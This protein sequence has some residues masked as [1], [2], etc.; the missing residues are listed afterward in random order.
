M[1]LD[2]INS[3]IRKTRLARKNNLIVVSPAEMIR[4]IDGV[5]NYNDELKCIEAPLPLNRGSWRGSLQTSALRHLEE[6]NCPLSYQP[7][8][9]I[10]QTSQG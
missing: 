1:S 7:S 6:C 4:I 10:H 3:E 8:D 2:E 5:Y 9:I